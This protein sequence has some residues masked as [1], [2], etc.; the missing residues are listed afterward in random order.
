MR[1]V[2]GMKQEK[3]LPVAVP[4]KFLNLGNEEVRGIVNPLDRYSPPCLGP[5][6]FLKGLPA[7]GHL[8]TQLLHLTVP[9]KKLWIEVVSVPHVHVAKKMIKSHIIGIAQ[10]IRSPQS[11]LANA[12]RPIACFLQ[13]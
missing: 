1:C 7:R 13:D 9:D 8:V 3:W 12:G 5:P 10:L 2:E 6:R 11:P 4:D